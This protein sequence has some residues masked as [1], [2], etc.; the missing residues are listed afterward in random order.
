MGHIVAS[1]TAKPTVLAAFSRAHSLHSPVALVGGLDLLL[2]RE[3]D[4]DLFRAILSADEARSLQ[5]LSERLLDE[6]K[7][8][9]HQGS[10]IYFETEHF[11]GDG[12][13]GA[14]VFK[15]GELIFDPSWVGIG[16]INHSLKLL[17]VSIRPPARDEFQT[18]GLDRHSVIF[19]GA[20][21]FRSTLVSGKV[22]SRCALPAFISLALM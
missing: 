17:G 19:S 22:R 2:M 1:L 11:D 9:S 4:L 21:I 5:Y 8:S 16:P 7:R 6:L 10:L 13:Q 15:D 12:G 3:I 14:A 18:V 20:R